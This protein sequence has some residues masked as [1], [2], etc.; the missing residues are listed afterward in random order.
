MASRETKKQQTE[1]AA[2]ET[3]KQQTEEKAV[4]KMTA[5]ERAAIERHFARCEA[6]PSI[7]CKVSRN[8]SDLQIGFDHPDRLVGRALVMDALRQPTRTF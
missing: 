6:T 7:R 4:H 8:G 3:K 2:G 5:A 1:E